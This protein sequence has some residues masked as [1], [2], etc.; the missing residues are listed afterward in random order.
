MKYQNILK[1]VEFGSSLNKSNLICI[2]NKWAVFHICI[3]NTW[4]IMCDFFIG[5]V[6]SEDDVGC[7]RM[8]LISLG[9]WAEK[10]QINKVQ[11]G[12]MQVNE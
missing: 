1:S 12:E 9:R 6:G 5:K 11:W 10:W 8:H 3:R 7:L 4:Q 2:L